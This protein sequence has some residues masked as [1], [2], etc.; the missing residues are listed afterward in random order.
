ML[1]IFL[2]F[3]FPQMYNYTSTLKLVAA[4]GQKVNIYGKKYH[5]EN[6][7]ILFIFY[8]EET[9]YLNNLITENL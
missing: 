7:E 2:C 4:F 3:Y 6:S 1:L 5:A 8:K 9:W